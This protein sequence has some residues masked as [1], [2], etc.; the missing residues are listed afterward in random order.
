MVQAI[1]IEPTYQTLQICANPSQLSLHKKTLIGDV[2][3]QATLNKTHPNKSGC[4]DWIRTN[5]LRGMNPMSYQ[6][7]LPCN[8]PYALGEE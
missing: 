5:D 6:T 4:R 8:N 3:C 7:A 1:G 2:F